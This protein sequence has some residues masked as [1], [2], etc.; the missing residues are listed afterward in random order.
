M[1][2][3]V[4]RS[5]Q[6]T[7]M[8][9]FETNENPKQPPHPLPSPRYPQ[10]LC[11]AAVSRLFS[12]CADF[13]TRVVLPAL[14]HDAVTACWLDGVVQGSE[15]AETVL[16]PLTD[17]ARLS[18]TDGDAERIELMERGAVY[19]CNM[20]RR[21]TTDETVDDIVRGCCAVIFDSL[22]EALTFEAR[23]SN[24]RAVSE[25]TVE[26]SLKGAKDAFVESLRVNTSL[27][28]RKLRSPA[29]KLT[30][31]TVGRKSGT[32]VGVMY[33][34]DVADPGIVA[35]VGRRLDAID[36]DGLLA[37]GDLE[38]YITDYPASP[39]PQLLH[40]ER[41]DR[42]STELLEGRVGLICDG[43]P[44]GFL[45]PATLPSFMS[46]PEDDSLHFTVATAL[47]VLRWFAL[48]LALTLPA[49]LVAVA[50]YHQEM[51]PT[52]LLLSMIEAKQR[53]PFGVAGETLAILL[54]F[55][56][57]QEAG[58]RLPDPVGQTVSIIGALIVGQ[59]AVEARVVSPI[60]VIVVA[61]AGISGYTMPS[62]DLSSAL[63]LHRFL[64]VFAALFAG[65]YGI[66]AA[67]CLLVWR[68]CTLESYGLAYTSPM[69]NS[70]RGLLGT[71]LVRPMHR[72]K[73][74][75]AGVAGPDL[76]RQR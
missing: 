72:R 38:D 23:T 16:R 17:A 21:K 71:L 43:L 50:M 51:L 18:R 41:A 47:S 64:L 66:V 8:C 20:K 67:L 11:A 57:L 31:T 62:Q 10:P 24:R 28:R 49:L 26:K 46:V 12:G 37:A 59:S 61:V 13:E 29:L 56:L 22:G 75:D 52:K 1:L 39:Y 68:L 55:E 25:P 53:V 58:L 54:A 2:H 74:R 5:G 34:E 6:N 36:I 73:F 44:I 30:Q 70:D 14:E 48:V 7:L 69:T 3:I 45:V 4:F 19:C 60:A 33:I 63:R 40:T 35:E 76:R 65:L 27:V 42:F 15:I 32:V 9:A